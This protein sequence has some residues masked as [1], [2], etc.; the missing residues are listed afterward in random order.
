MRDLL[1]SRIIKL[2]YEIKGFSTQARRSRQQLRMEIA[3]CL[4]TA[5]V[6]ACL[7]CS[8]PHNLSTILFNGIF[9]RLVS[10]MTT[11]PKDEMEALCI[12]R[13]III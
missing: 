3:H 11:K 9:I 8:S 2:E 6:L 1:R 12:F 4:L 5:E 7:R 13:E 10:G